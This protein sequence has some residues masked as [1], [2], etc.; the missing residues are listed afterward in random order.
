MYVITT[1]PT[2]NVGDHLITRSAKE[3]IKQVKGDVEIL[4]YSMQ[5]DLSNELEKIN[6]CKAIIVPS[7]AIREPIHPETFRFVP[8][9]SKIKIPIFPLGMSWKGFP[10]DYE[11]ANTFKLQN[12]TVKFLSYISKQVPKILC[13][14][15][16]TCHILK[17]H[18]INNFVMGGDPAWYDFPSLGKPMKRPEEIKS[19]VFTTP[20]AGWFNEQAKNILDMLSETFPNARKIC[21]IHGGN[22]V[23]DVGVGQYAES[24]GFET[25]DVSNHLEQIDYYETMDLHVGY[26][27]H[28]HISF[29]RKRIPSILLNEDSRGCGFSYS[30]GVG[31]FDAFNRLHGFKQKWHF[32]THRGRERIMAADEKLPER[33]KTYLKEE[34][35][36]RFRKFV[37]VAELIDDTYEKVMKPYV[38]SIP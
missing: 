32:A 18:G 23:E 35:E 7:F 30:V 36:S 1:P 25:I 26:R 21:S 19:L 38:E 3:I 29:L 24:I 2:K 27:L 33:V 9:M 6:N 12:T 37:G 34:T 14:D 5:D 15:H 31:G 28:G 20:H 13:R 22:G 10:G 4:E 8:D 17:N 11:T 16:L